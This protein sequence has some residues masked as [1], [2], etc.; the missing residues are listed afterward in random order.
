MFQ[1]FSF[2]TPQL[3]TSSRN[4]S[5]AV[6]SSVP[7]S[8]IVTSVPTAVT[9]TSLASYQF[10]FAGAVRKQNTGKL[11]SLSVTFVAVN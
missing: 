4:N 5:I 2:A 11:L 1:T 3:L 6:S 8:V 9:A 10:S 7:S